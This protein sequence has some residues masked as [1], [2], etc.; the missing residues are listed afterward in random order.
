METE[1]KLKKESEQPTNCRECRQAF[2]DPDLRIFQG[3]PED[4]VSRPIDFSIV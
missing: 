2:D 1:T 4:A 3:D